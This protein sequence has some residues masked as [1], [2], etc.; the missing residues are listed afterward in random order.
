MAFYRVKEEGSG[1]SCLKR[2]TTSDSKSNPRN[3]AKAPSVKSDKSRTKIEQAGPAAHSSKAAGSGLAL[4]RKISDISMRSSTSSNRT[5]RRRGSN[6]SIQSSNSSC[7]SWMMQVDPP[8]NLRSSASRSQIHTPDSLSPR[9]RPGTPRPKDAQ[10]GPAFNLRS[11]A[12]RTKLTDTWMKFRVQ[13]TYSET[14]LR[15]EAKPLVVKSPSSGGSLSPIKV[16]KNPPEKSVQTRR[17]ER[18]KQDED[19]PNRPRR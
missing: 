16:A 4:V 8:Y 11:S 2:K 10:A 15:E 3:E 7:A 17:L 19:N 12:S 9:Q 1:K 14:S 13:K 6:M 5:L 18:Q